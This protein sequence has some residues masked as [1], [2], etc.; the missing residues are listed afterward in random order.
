MRTSGDGPKVGIDLLRRLLLVHDLVDN[1][2]VLEPNRV[3]VASSQKP[4]WS[5]VLAHPAGVLVSLVVVRDQNRLDNSPLARCEVFVVVH[6]FV[7]PASRVV[8]VGVIHH[9]VKQTLANTLPH[10][11]LFDKHGQIERVSV[12]GRFVQVFVEVDVTNDV[13]AQVARAALWPMIFGDCNKEGKL[14]V[15]NFVAAI[16]NLCLRARVEL[17][18]ADRSH[19]V[20]VYILRNDQYCSG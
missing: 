10:V 15:D 5:Q 8:R 2:A 7:A 17:S 14:V 4:K 12:H 3:E 11:T 1:L 19:I 9:L 16:T 20:I 6:V 13:F 18:G